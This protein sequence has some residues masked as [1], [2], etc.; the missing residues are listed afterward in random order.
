M[1]E[2]KI[3]VMALVSFL[4]QEQLPIVAKSA[5]IHID[6]TN[7]QV[8]IKQY[9]LFSVAPYRDM[10][11]AGL[12]SLMQ[13]QKLRSDMAPLRLVSKN[14]YEEDGKLNAKLHLQYDDL[15]DLREMSFYADDEG[16]LS[17]SYMDDF[18]YS[19]QTGSIDGSHVRFHTGQDVKFK[20]GRK[21]EYPEGIYSLLDDW[22]ALSASKYMDVT[23]FFPI[24][25]FNKTRTFIFK[26]GDRKTYRN[27]DN[28][29]P[30]Y[31]FENFD[32]YLGTGDQRSVLQLGKL[33]S[34]EY[35]EMVIHADAYYTFYSPSHKPLNKNQQHLVEG[36]VYWFSATNK[37]QKE[38]RA[39][40]KELIR[41][42]EQ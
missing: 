24:K 34:K 18:E 19:L 12:D 21:G 8:V 27:F 26:N 30:H 4:S 5:E 28:G 11:K 36:K 42:A 35:I 17:Y 33:R 20:M 41:S 13:A 32:V 31:S 22:K 38:V 2:I 23:D 1:E 40:V 39:Y 10:A 15:K 6:R 3:L 9:D 16:N 29:N 14:F 25:D 7:Q 37:K